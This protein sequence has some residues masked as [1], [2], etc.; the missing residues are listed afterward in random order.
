MNT[1]LRRLAVI[2]SIT[3]S[4]AAAH[5]VVS[6]GS[7]HPAVHGAG[8]A[9]ANRAAPAVWSAGQAGAQA[10][11]CARS[12]DGCMPIVRPFVPCVELDVG[13]AGRQSVLACYPLLRGTHPVRFP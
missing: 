3:V 9:R 4:L 10:M 12:I 11:S 13:T 8:G 1:T 2:G 5:Q 7:A 6:R